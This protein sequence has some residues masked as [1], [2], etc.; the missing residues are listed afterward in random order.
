MSSDETQKPLEN[1]VKDETIYSEDLTEQFQ[2]MI[3]TINTCR[4][5]TPRAARP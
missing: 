4:P 1:D 5:S 2:N 3:E